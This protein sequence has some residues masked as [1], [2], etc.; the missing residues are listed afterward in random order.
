MPTLPLTKV[1]EHTESTNLGVYF[2]PGD[3]Q[4][5]GPAREVLVKYSGVPEDEVVS[6]VRKVVR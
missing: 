6:H 4:M 2:T 1:D 5:N 3:P